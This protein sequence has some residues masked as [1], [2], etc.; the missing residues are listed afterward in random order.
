MQA[1]I[2]PDGRWIAY[3]ADDSGALEVYVQ[4]YPEL[5]ERYQVSVGGGGQPQWRSDQSELYYIAPDLT[6][7]AIA[8]GEGQGYPFGS[9]QRLFRAPV[10]GGP[11]DARDHYVAM[12]DGSRFLLDG[13]FGDSEDSPITVVVNWPAETEN[14]SMPSL[15]KHE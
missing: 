11:D 15:S 5:D 4:R 2:S 7:I 6:L 3:V 14:P 1:R 8:V 13:A 10:A 9:P 12:A